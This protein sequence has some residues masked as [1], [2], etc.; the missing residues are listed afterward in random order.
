[1][2]TIVEKPKRK[3]VSIACAA[4]RKA[5]V[6]CND[7]RPCARCVRKGI[8][9]LCEDPL[10]PRC[11]ICPL[12]PIV[13]KDACL[14]DLNQNVALIPTACGFEPIPKK[15]SEMNPE[16]DCS[17]LLNFSETE[18]DSIC[19]KCPFS[20]LDE[21]LFDFE[22]DEDEIDIP[23]RV[24][25]LLKAR[26][27]AGFVTPYIYSTAYQQLI[28]YLEHKMGSIH[29]QLILQSFSLLNIPDKNDEFEYHVA[30]KEQSL[31]GSSVPSAIWR[32]TG[33]IYKK[34]VAFDN[35]IKTESPFIF[36]ILSQD[37]AVQ[38]FEWAANTQQNDKGFLGQCRLK[39][40]QCISVSI[41]LIG[42]LNILGMYGQFFC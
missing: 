2:N 22:G 32:M 21:I 4:C 34:N 17:E 31:F 5:H 26:R 23:Q 41:T 38:I 19:E 20:A 10:K 14:P 28:Y 16:F 13:P 12:Q 37:S 35:L 7:Q 15:Y 27:N 40:N 39:N 18:M 25:H 8:A 30:F 3:R 33:H 9:H 6:S 11:R 24:H 42:H 36:D 29:R 1:M